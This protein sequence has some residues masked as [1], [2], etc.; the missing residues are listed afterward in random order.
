MRRF[1]PGLSQK[2]QLLDLFLAFPGRTGFPDKIV[3]QQKITAHLAQLHP[4]RP[5]LLFANQLPQ[6]ASRRLFHDSF[7]HQALNNHLPLRG[8]AF[9][10]QGSRDG[11]FALKAAQ[12]R[13]LSCAEMLFFHPLLHGLIKS[14]H[15]LSSLPSPPCTLLSDP[16]ARQEFWARVFVPSSLFSERKPFFS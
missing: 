11:R 14:L 7:L 13:C 15:A 3:P 1:R 4:L 9:S 16:W 2:Q 6:P 10:F 8:R 12:L 5:R